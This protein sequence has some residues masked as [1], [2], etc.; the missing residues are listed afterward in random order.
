[1]T[2]CPSW[3]ASTTCVATSFPLGKIEG[4]REAHEQ[5]LAY[6]RRLGSSEAEARALGGLADAAYAQ[7]CMRSAGAHFSRCVALSHEHGF[8]ASPRR[9]ASPGCCPPWRRSMP[10]S[11]ARSRDQDWWIPNPNASPEWLAPL[12]GRHIIGVAGW[13]A[14][15][16]ETKRRMAAE[17][18]ATRNGEAND[19]F[20]AGD[21][22]LRKPQAVSVMLQ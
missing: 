8:P 12:P 19:V 11:P 18:T 3:R 15:R 2:S 13:A 5:G 9:C 7:G 14:R 10:R 21:F 20:L 17:A 6:A 1:M 16:R 22:L 4:C